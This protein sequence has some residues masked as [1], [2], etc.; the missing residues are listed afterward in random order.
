MNAE[1]ALDDLQVSAPAARPRLASRPALS[2]SATSGR[3]V[4]VVDDD[5]DMVVLCGLYLRAGGFDVLEATTG[6]TALAMARA[7]RP[8]VILLD[9]MLPDMDGTEVLQVLAADPATAGIPVIMLTARVDVRDEQAAWELG[10]FDYITKPFERERLLQI[11]G[12][13]LDPEK[14]HESERRRNNA[15]QRLR[16]RDVEAWQ[17]LAAIL[18]HCD[19]GVIVIDKTVDGA[20][21]GWNAAAERLYG[22]SA[23]EVIGRPISILAPA[24][25]LEEVAGLLQR[26]A[27]GERIDHFETVRQHR[28]GHRID[29]AVSIV[30]M[31]DR[32]GKL[33]GA[34]VVVRDLTVRRQ[35][36]ARLQALVE[37]APDAMVIVDDRGLIELVNRQTEKLFGYDRGELVGQRVEILIP[38]RHRAGHRGLREGY[39]TAP[40]AR[41]MGA[42]VDLYGLRKDGTEF[43]IE[44]SLSPLETEHRITVTATIRDVTDRK[45]AELMF[46]GLLESAPDA[47]VIVD[48]NGCIELVN[49]E[50]EKLFGYDRAELVGQPVEVLVPPRFRAQHIKERSGYTDRPVVRPMGSDLD[51]YGLRKDGTEFPAEISLSPLRMGDRLTITATVREVTERKGA[52]LMFRGLVESAPDAMVIVDG[53]GRIQLVNAQ[54]ERLFGYDRSELVGQPV[55]I[56]VPIRSRVRH[57]QDRARYTAEPRVRPMGA[58][59]DLY[60]LRKDGTEF[61]VEISLSPLDHRDGQV[62]SA[63]IRDVTERKQVEIARAAALQR[64]REASGR[65]RELDR[66]RDDFLSTVSHELRTPLTA[67][68]GFSE[69]LTTGLAKEPETEQEFHVA[70]RIVRASKRLDHLMSDLLDFIHLERGQLT[71]RVGPQSAATLAATAVERSAPILEAH[72]V[73]LSVDD[74]LEVMADPAALCRV[75][76]KL[77]SNA[78]KFSPAGSTITVSAAPEPTTIA[79]SVTD[80]GQ[81]IPTDERDKIFE[82]FYR[83]GPDNRRPGTGI[84]LAIVKEFTE[85]Q[86]GWVDVGA[87]EGG[88]STFTIH[89][90]RA[91]PGTDGG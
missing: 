68:K 23:E 56:L 31:R 89:L 41:P 58:G 64:E 2:V 12:T 19:D 37:T 60:G 46:R 9:F 17:R 7:H 4:L 86:D 5:A 67:I 73:S 52:E 49:H 32:S 25:R 54:T 34:T 76:E 77:L 55:E 61:P 85:A 33:T 22:Y 81:G 1:P 30:P 78:A 75:L 24:D 84:G 28:D 38:T 44:V 40:L 42:G 16:V 87:A 45:Q 88:G 36:D 47:M 43:P 21:T 35:A 66:L 80:E 14:E 62:V 71:L 13:A 6:S 11:V 57:A 3:E 90:P 70:E 72:E 74:D 8:G 48:E 53:D 65:L 50:T 63:A 83:A 29:V 26:A 39:F 27:R 82:R 20:I 15:L 18:D 51:L 10:V 91:G 79:I 59:L 69:M